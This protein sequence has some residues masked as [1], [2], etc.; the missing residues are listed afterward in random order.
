MLLYYLFLAEFL[1]ICFSTN[2]TSKCLRAEYS[3]STMRGVLFLPLLA[4]SCM[5]WAWAV[6]QR[7]LHPHG[8]LSHSR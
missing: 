8:A 3:C 4:S 5:H 6:G 2:P 1:S 7:Y